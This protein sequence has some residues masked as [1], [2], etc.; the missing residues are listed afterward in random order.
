MISVKSLSDLMAEKLTDITGQKETISKISYGLEMILG[1]TTKAICLLLAAYLANLLV[2]IVFLMVAII[3]LRMIVG[4]GHCTSSLR[5]LITS[6]ITYFSMAAAS[7][8]LAHQLPSVYLLG[9]CLASFF[10]FAFIIDR[11]GPGNSVNYPVLSQEMVEKIRRKIFTLMS[12]YTVVTLNTFYFVQE[13]ILS[14]ILASAA[15]GVVWQSLM[16]T[17]YGQ[18]LIAILDKSLLYAKIK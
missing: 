15:I 8:F 9:F 10:L 16:L 4:G 11:Y 3:P 7:V 13:G 1:E 17:T 14:L 6:M 2:P 12:I 18:R 5:C